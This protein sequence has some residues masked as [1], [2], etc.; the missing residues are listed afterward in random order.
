MSFDVFL[1]GFLDGDAR[2]GGVDTMRRALAAHIEHEDP[3]TGFLSVRCDDGIGEIYTSSD[4][5]MATHIGG[6]QLWDALV[7][8][9]VDADWVII[10]VGCPTCITHEGQRAHLPEGLDEDAVLVRAGEELLRV[11]RSS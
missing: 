5:V 4:G 8:G 9:A 3:E 1:Q 7:R 11:I 10:P 2:P 6:T